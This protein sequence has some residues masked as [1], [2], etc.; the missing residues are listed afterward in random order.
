[1]GRHRWDP[2]VG[3]PQGLQIP[4][5]VGSTG[6]GPTQSTARSAAWD[7]KARGFYLPAGS[8]VDAV[9]QRIL[10]A[11]PHLPPLG[12]FTGWAACRLH[13]AAFH[14]G[15]GRDGITRL[16]VPIAVGTRGWV[17]RRA[18]LAYS[19]FGLDATAIQVAAGVPVTDPVRATYDAMLAA[20]SLV[21]AIVELEKSVMGRI[22]SIEQV[23][24]FIE[25][26][27]GTQGVRQAREAAQLASE[28]SRSPQEVR[29]RF[30]AER[31]ARLPALLVNAT[32]YTLD[33]SRIGEVDLA[34]P[35]S[36]L[37]VEFDGADHEEQPR[38]HGD[39]IKLERLRAAGAEVLRVTTP[40]LG[41]PEGLVATMRAAR[42]RALETPDERR[43]YRFVARAP[44]LHQELL[45]AR[46][47]A[48]LA[49]DLE[50]QMR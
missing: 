25:A 31:V 28:F 44:S 16:P 41:E 11:A 35:T 32:A 24:D 19:L 48:E 29:T 30:I 22:A 9:E 20:D 7:R 26:K 49:R 4:V 6:A 5:P 40:M 45:E 36:G 2:Q 34:E 12:A 47:V 1:M 27:R 39:A 13:G 14:D 23:R 21:E 33:G 18:G 37:V 43:R 38:R 10:N 8:E 17:R 50:R 42:Q 15:L 46:V 3:L